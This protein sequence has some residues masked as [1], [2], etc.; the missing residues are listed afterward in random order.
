MLED[1]VNGFVH[2]SLALIT[3]K[4]K[5]PQTPKTSAGSCYYLAASRSCSTLDLNDVVSCSVSWW[6]GEAGIDGV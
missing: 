1:G 3:D 6:C 4:R 5:T 2:Q